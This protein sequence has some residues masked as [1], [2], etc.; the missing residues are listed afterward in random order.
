M[1]GLRDVLK[2]I[3]RIRITVETERLLVVSKQGRAVEGWCACCGE[4]VELI[5][6]EEAAAL[7]GMSP[8]AIRRQ[9][10][11]NL[12][13]DVETPDGIRFICLNSLLQ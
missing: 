7:V 9:I 12:L 3:K 5:R 2:K 11:T 1:K 4:S 8:R 10:E 13:H 6:L